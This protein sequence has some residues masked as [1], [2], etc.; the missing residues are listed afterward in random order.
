MFVQYDKDF[1]I[2]IEHGVPL[3]EYIPQN[4][5]VRWPI[6]IMKEGDSFWVPRSKQEGARSAVNMY[7]LKNPKSRWVVIKEIQDS[8]QGLRIY[9]IEDS[10][11]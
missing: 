1:T 3:P 2:H 10:N 6:N 5:R 7:K 11:D 9:R 4:S 8:I